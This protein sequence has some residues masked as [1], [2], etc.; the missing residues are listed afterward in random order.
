V[1]VGPSRRY[2]P[3]LDDLAGAIRAGRQVEHFS[4]DHDLAVQRALLQACGLSV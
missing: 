2:L 3:D 4:P 1:P